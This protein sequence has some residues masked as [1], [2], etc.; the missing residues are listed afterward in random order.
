M[1]QIKRKINQREVRL[2]NWGNSKAVLLTK[3]ILEEAGFEKTDDVV[4]EVE[5]ESQRISLVPK[6]KLT[7]FE[8]LFVGYEDEKPDDEPLWDEAEQVGK[9]E[10]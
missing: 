7:P 1:S 9:E 4:L 8:K 10:W 5:I 6:S 2:Q 3:D